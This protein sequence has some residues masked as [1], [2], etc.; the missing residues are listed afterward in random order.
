MLYNPKECRGEKICP[1]F[2]LENSRPLSPWGPLDFLSTCLGIDSL[3]L[4]P[5]QVLVLIN[6]L[7]L[8]ATEG[9][10]KSVER[11]F[12]FGKGEKESLKAYVRNRSIEKNSVASQ[13]TYHAQGNSNPGGSDSEESICNSGD[14]SLIPRSERSPGEGNGYSLQYLV[15]SILRT[16]KHSELQTMGLQKAGHD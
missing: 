15:W 7:H 13:S 8:S 6:E 9:K 16:E 4:L 1:F 12:H 10:E 5:Q 11:D 14:L 3:S 2:L